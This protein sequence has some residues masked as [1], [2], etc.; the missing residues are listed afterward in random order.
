MEQVFWVGPRAAPP[1]LGDLLKQHDTRLLWFENA[2]GAEEALKTVEASVV[3]VTADWPDASKTVGR[4]STARPDLQILL[5]TGFGLPRAVVLSLWGGAAG[6]LEFKS[7]TRNEIVL[8]IQEWISRYRQH[9][10]ERMLM[11]RLHTLNEEF[12][13]TIVT[14]QKRNIDLEQ[15]LQAS[16]G[17]AVPAEGP[18]QVLIVDDEQVVHDVLKVILGK[19]GHKVTSVL[20]GESGVKLLWE[21]GFHLVI[22]DKNL[23]GMSGIE[24]MR[25]VKE[26]SPDTDVMMITGYSSKDSAVEALD[27]GAAAYLE[28]PFDDVR[29]VM[30]RIEKVIVGQRE[31][32]KKKAYLNLIKDRNKDFLDKY[33]ALRADLEVWLAA[34]SGK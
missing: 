16:K 26:L 9:K 32:T 19:R 12:L 10:R 31:R 34:H 1:Q 23:P 20:D 30:E 28:K 7:Q 15:E 33:R 13:K 6:V 3:V 2:D 17:A 21:H 11:M 22:T 29:L 27:V 25:Q 24:V 18:A 14:V 4:M 8:E 5:A